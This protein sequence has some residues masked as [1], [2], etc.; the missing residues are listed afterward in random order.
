MD[1]TGTLMALL[2]IMAWKHR[3]FSVRYAWPDVLVGGLAPR[4][5]GLTSSPHS[6]IMHATMPFTGSAT[7]VPMQR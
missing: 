7:C 6:D 2:R 5:P 4:D 3:K 1:P